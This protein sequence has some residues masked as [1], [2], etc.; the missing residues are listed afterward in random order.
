MTYQPKVGDR[1]R[2]TLVYEGVARSGAN[3][4]SMS[5]DV[6]ATV[7]VEAANGAPV[8]ARDNLRYLDV[9]L[10]SFEKLQDP[11]PEWVNGDVIRVSALEPQNPY[12]TFI[13]VDGSWQGAWNA[14][15]SATVVT[16]HW[17]NGNLEILYK[18]DAERAA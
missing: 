14:G 4:D 5:G 16:G 7:V 9:R 12:A 10:W 15:L 11:E 18:A 17:D 6:Y 2:A 13:R 8:G 1:V 3:N